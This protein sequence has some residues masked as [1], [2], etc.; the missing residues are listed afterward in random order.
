MKFILL[1][2]LSMGLF[3][4]SVAHSNSISS[5][6]GKDDAVYV[7]NNKNKTIYSINSDQHKVPAS[8]LKILTSLSALHYLG[9]DYRFKT[10]FYV[11]K[12]NDLI[13]KGYGDPFLI[14][15]T[16]SKIANEIKIWKLLKNHQINNIILDHTFFEAESVPGAI[17][18]SAEPYDAQTG[19]LCAN[20]NTVNFYYDT[21]GEIKSAEEQ[22]PLLPFT[23]KQIKKSGLRKG[24]IVLSKN[25]QNL[26]PGY[27]LQYFLAKQGIQIN[28][29]IKT[30]AITPS[31]DRLIY[32]HLSTYTVAELIQQLL[33]YSNNFIAN[34]LFLAIGAKEY[35]SPATFNKGIKAVRKY[36]DSL[37]AKDKLISN[38]YL[39]E[40]SGLSRENRITAQAMDAVLKHFMPYRHLL[41]KGEN[42][43]YK[44][45]TL[46]GIST[47]AGYI[48]C[49]N[50][51][52]RYVII[53]NTPGLS[54]KMI[55]E[56][57]QMNLNKKA[58]CST[59]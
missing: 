40:G 38:Y 26:Y 21:L 29:S 19:A 24:R 8:I 51:F 42:E 47:R 59:N 56:N 52:Y 23:I 22:T 18:D 36:T 49:N 13:I 2:F 5:L 28:G 6:L 15:E 33:E 27:L 14:S 30:G 41:R 7:T 3:S 39:I 53:C 48:P 4:P 11:N 46:T 1:I 37:S 32:S 43:L 50:K 45:G 9:E 10:E 34:Q 25:E 35:G 58:I 16:I 44:T 12:G 54:S 20:F 17:Q 55:L 57:I 31:S